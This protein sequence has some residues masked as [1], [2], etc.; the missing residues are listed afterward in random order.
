VEERA[1]E[2]EG[3]YGGIIDK[4]RRL[5]VSIRIGFVVVVWVFGDGNV[6]G[7]DFDCVV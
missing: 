2:G 5:W 7:W 1:G 6:G 4:A 3:A